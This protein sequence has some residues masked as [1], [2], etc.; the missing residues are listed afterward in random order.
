MADQQQ[1]SSKVK[2]V[3]DMVFLVDVTGS[4]TPCIEA[5]KN[6]ISTFITSLTTSSANTPSIVKNWRAKAVGYR[7]FTSDKVPFVDN[8]FVD[9]VEAFQ[10][11]LAELKAQG[12]GDEPESLLDALYKVATM[13]ATG[14]GAQ[15]DPK[16]WRYSSEA[17]RS[18]IV[19]SDASIK[20][21]M[22][23]PSGGTVEDVINALQSNRIVL[24]LFAPDFEC[25]K[26]LEEV[27]KATWERLTG[28]KDPQESM[29]L[30]T[31]DQKNFQKTMEKLGK[32]LTATLGATPLL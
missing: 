10:A 30:F 12:G 6:N 17:M 7:D 1:Q 11:Q 15:A 22:V 23:E 3:I 9:S 24:T 14:K 31:K 28:G 26:D 18:I 2:G 21:T 4:M 32:T 16:S 25:Y 20:P 8:P 27:N 5:L 13:P 29:A 19:F